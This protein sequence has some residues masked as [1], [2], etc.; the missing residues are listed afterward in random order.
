L[1]E[2]ANICG[3][4]VQNK[5]SDHSKYPTLKKIYISTVKKGHNSTALIECTF[6]KNTAKFRMSQRE[7]CRKY[8]GQTSYRIYHEASYS[9]FQNKHLNCGCK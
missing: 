6:Q 1:I 3:P 2:N 8:K 4:S 5:I 9:Y 7:L